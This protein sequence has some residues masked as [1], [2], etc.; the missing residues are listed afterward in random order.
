MKALLVLDMQKAILE[1][2]DFS[3]EKELIANLLK[4]FKAENEPIIFLKHRDNNPE[5]TLYFEAA[6]SELVEEYAEFADYIVE[7]TTPSAFKG[8][9][10]EEV[11]TKHKVDHVVIVGFNTEFCCLF[12]S[13]AAFEKGYKVTLIEDATGTANDEEVYEMPGLDI[14]DFIGS[15]LDWSN[16]IEV[17]YYDEYIETYTKKGSCAK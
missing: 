16:V 4:R 9:S 13:I 7:K 6:G 2:K 8:T 12:T 3:V 10:V 1:C 14:K 11:L 5:S 15:V 17:L